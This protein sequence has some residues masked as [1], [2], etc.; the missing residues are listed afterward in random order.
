VIEELFTGENPITLDRDACGDAFE[1]AR[2]QL[3]ARGS[4]STRQGGGERTLGG[5][6]LVLVRLHGN[7]LV[8]D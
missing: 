4:K 5:Q 8:R 1:P 2:R 3:G 7:Q 6:V